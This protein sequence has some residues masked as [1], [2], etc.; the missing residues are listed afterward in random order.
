MGF[1]WLLCWTRG[2]LGFCQEDS[3]D[4]QPLLIC[5][6]GHSTCTHPSLVPLKA[7]GSRSPSNSPLS[8]C[9]CGCFVAI[10]LLGAPAF[11]G[12]KCVRFTLT[13]GIYPYTVARGG[14]HHSQTS[15][16][17]AVDRWV[18]AFVQAARIQDYYFLIFMGKQCSKCSKAKRMVCNRVANKKSG[19]QSQQ[20]DRPKT[21]GGRCSGRAAKWV[22]WMRCLFDS[23]M[24]ATK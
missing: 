17:A 24:Q 19:E 7:D 18:A 11:A 2:G 1:V 5:G 3:E 16:T 12:I 13:S 9:C 10:E 14:P 4:S 6:A 20:Q 15:I 22:G 21:G 8:V 23:S